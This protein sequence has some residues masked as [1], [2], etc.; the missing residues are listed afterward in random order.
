MA[1]AFVAVDPGSTGVWTVNGSSAALSGQLQIG[2]AGGTDGGSATMTISNGSH[3]TTGDLTNVYQTGTLTIGSTT[4]DASSFAT[5][6]M[7]VNGNVFYNSGSFVANGTFGVG[8]NVLL[9]SRASG[10][11]KLLETGTLS[12][13]SSAVVDLNDNDALFHTTDETTVRTAIKTGRNGGTWTGT[14]LLSTAAKNNSLHNTTLGYNTGTQ[15]K[16]VGGRTTF[17]G[18]T[19]ANSD[20]LVKYTYYGDANLDGKVNFDDYARIDSGFNSGATDWFNGDFNDDGKVNFD[21][22]AL[23]DPAFNNQGAQILMRDGGLAGPGGGRALTLA[24]AEGAISPNQAAQQV[25]RD[26]RQ[27][28]TAEGM[29]DGANAMTHSVPEPTTLGLGGV[30]M[31]GMLSRRRR[32]R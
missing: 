30:A 22:Y 8:G 5:T 4:G 23:I 17:N 9:S 25:D 3:V 11:K 16:S 28:V 12:L 13:T 10:G 18:K 15:Y 21:D 31:L 19:V 27:A 32:S 1:N 20:I 14:G 26:L 2:G 24:V 29:S 6:S 7:V